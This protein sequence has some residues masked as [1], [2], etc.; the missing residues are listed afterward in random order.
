MKVVK[1][2][3]RN[4]RHPIRSTILGAIA[5][6]LATIALVVVASGNSALAASSL[7]NGNFE[8]GDLTGWSVTSGGDAYA[9]L[10]PSV[11]TGYDHCYPGPGEGCW[12]LE[13]ISPQE[14]SYFAVVPVANS[15]EVTSISQ[16]FEATSGD[17]VSGWAFFD[18]S[19]QTLYD[20][21]TGANDTKGQVVIKS[22]SGTTLATPFE[23][24]TSGTG[25]GATGWMYWEYTF[26]GLTGTAQFQIEARVQNPGPSACGGCSHMGLDDVKTSTP[27]NDPDTTKP[28]TSATRSVQSN[29]AGWNKENVT[30]TLKATDN[31]GGSGVEKIAYSASGAQSVAQTDA[32][33]DSVEVAFAQEGTTTLTYYATDKAGNVEDQKTLSVKIDKMAPTGSV[34][35]NDGDPRTSSRLVTLTLSATDP[36]PGSGVTQMRISNTQSGLSSASWEDYST[37][38]PWPLTSGK[39]TKTV[40][41][42][43]RDGAGNESAVV[44]DTIRFAR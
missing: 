21:S 3:D 18:E 11:V 15:S 33:G 8:T 20:P 35:I 17:K 23:Q 24:S 9:W 1:A 29:A 5:A 36:S 14:G 40:Y 38:K 16:P 25:F 43:Y 4:S 13:T 30:V 44:T 31:Q 2:V 27:T 19:G 12:G 32:P 34:S 42:R 10:Q 39:G 37:T 7:V 6:A 41:V 28:S 22:A 26:T